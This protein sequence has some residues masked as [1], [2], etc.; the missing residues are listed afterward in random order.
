M[1]REKKQKLSQRRD[2]VAGLR[3]VYE[4]PVDVFRDVGM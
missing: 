2:L 1:R 3:G 4:A